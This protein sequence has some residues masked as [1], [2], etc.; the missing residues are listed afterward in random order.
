MQLSCNLQ[1][2]CFSASEHS[3]HAAVNSQ[4]FIDAVYVRLDCAK[5]YIGFVTDFRICQPVCQL[6]EYSLLRP[7]KHVPV[8]SCPG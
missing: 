1:Y 2:A 5:L 8:R 3:L 6:S 4:F 7:C